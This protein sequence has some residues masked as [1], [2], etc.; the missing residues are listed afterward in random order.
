VGWLTRTHAVAVLIG[1]IIGT[2][3]TS[4]IS[5][6]GVQAQWLDDNSKVKA[7]QATPFDVVDRPDVRVVKDF[8]DGWKLYN[9]RFTVSAKN[10]SNQP[11]PFSYSVFTADLL[12]IEAKQ[13][14]HGRALPL[15]SPPDPFDSSRT[16]TMPSDAKLVWTR[17]S[18]VAY[19]GTDDDKVLKMLDHACGAHLDG[20]G[21]TGVRP[22]QSTNSY[23]DGVLV[24]ARPGDFV[25]LSTAFGVKNCSDEDAATCSLMQ[26]IVQLP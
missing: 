16:T 3:V 5:L 17:L 23:T 26:E 1:G 21:L 22:P 14:P 13:A 2:A 24:T 7:L 18:C 19:I 25:G 11:L 12:T 6:H 20:G 9:V 10:E 8:R 15:D 4:I